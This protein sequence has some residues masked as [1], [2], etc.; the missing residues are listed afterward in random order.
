M[1]AIEGT[2]R[3]RLCWLPPNSAPPAARNSSGSTKLKKA[4]LGLRQNI[5]RSSRY[6]RQPN[7]KDWVP[8]HPLC[9]GRQL[10]VDVLERGAPDRQLIQAPPF[11]QRLRRQLRQQGGRILRLVLVQ[12]AV[13]ATV[14][15]P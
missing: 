2:S 15:D 12:A 5:L 7:A 10:Q 3:L 4:A 11:G 8:T 14:G 13:G 6:W 9:I 1:P